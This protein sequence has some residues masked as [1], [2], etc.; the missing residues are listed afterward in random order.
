MKWVLLET[1]E[2]PAGEGAGA[3]KWVSHLTSAAELLRDAKAAWHSSGSVL[4]LGMWA[5]DWTASQACS[6]SEV[7]P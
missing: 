2:E 1:L 7:N 4:P 5:L 6:S 3:W